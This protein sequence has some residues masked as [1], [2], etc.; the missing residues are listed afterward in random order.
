MWTALSSTLVTTSERLHVSCKCGF[1]TSVRA[2]D[3]IAGSSTRCRACSSKKKAQNIPKE[4]RQKIAKKASE[5]AA[6]VARLKKANHPYRVK[7]GLEYDTLLNK[8][9]NIKQRCN[10]PKNIAYKNYGGRGIEFRFS[11]SAE[12]SMWVLDNLGVKPN[13]KH[14]IDRIDNNLH[15][16]KGNLRWAD[17]REQARNKRMYK[18]TE[19]GERIRKLQNLR[20]DLTYETIRTWAILGYS[21]NEII[22]R[23]KYA[24]T[25]I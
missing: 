9:S 16:E 3:I 4:V 2:S 17:Y 21:D 20:P 10:N 24:S 19:R 22:N 13:N 12:F 11:S 25:S 7:Y 15:Y 6:R 1:H 5:Q 23:K 14:S 18:R 8:A